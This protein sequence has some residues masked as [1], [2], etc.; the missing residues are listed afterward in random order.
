VVKSKVI[1]A[2]AFW[3]PKLAVVASHPIQKP[4]QIEKKITFSGRRFKSPLFCVA[5]C[6]TCNTFTRTVLKA[7]GGGGGDG[8][9]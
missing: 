4:S 8:R 3:G 9:G 1:R 2:N 6:N 7:E 5:T